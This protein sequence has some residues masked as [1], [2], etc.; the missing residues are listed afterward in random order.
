MGDFL[1]RRSQALEACEKV[2]NGIENGVISTSSALLLCRKI[3][4]LVN[5]IEGQEWLSYEY[6]GYPRNNDG[7]LTT[8]AW[9]IAVQHGRSYIDVNDK[10]TYVW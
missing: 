3:A 1:T 7:Y 5:D 2:I 8:S 6:G 9:D 10:K 4:R